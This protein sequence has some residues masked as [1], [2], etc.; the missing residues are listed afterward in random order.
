MEMMMRMIGIGRMIGTRR[1][2]RR[3]P[4]TGTGTG[5]GAPARTGA[6]MM[7]EMRTGIRTMMRRV[8][9][10]GIGTI[11]RME[12]ST[13]IGTIMRRDIRIGK[14]KRTDFTMT[15]SLTTKIFIM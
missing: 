5:T 10:T 13:E 9:R 2:T 14:M 3:R 1:R 7:M 8:M 4:G 15:M 6:V 11:M 12:M